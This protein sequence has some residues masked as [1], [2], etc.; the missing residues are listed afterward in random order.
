MLEF[1]LSTLIKAQGFLINQVP[2]GQ[3][4]RKLET[5]TSLHPHPDAKPYSPEPDNPAVLNRLGCRV[6]GSGFR[7]KGSGFRV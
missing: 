4:P 6:K 7:V 1:I 2:T 5:P 3:K